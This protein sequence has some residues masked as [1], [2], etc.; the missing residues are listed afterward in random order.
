MKK[1]KAGIYTSHGDSRLVGMAGRVGSIPVLAFVKNDQVI[2][3]I[4]LEELI[5]LLCNGPFI[6]VRD[7]KNEVINTFD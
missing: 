7:F 1:R 2:G 4:T 5:S 6:V 3:Y